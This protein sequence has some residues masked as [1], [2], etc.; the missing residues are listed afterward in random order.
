VI[1][2]LLARPGVPP[3]L[4]LLALAA[5]WEGAARW[6]GIDGLAPA[7]AAIRQL[8]AILLDPESL[9]H[10]IASLRRMAVGFAAALLV[11]VPVG[12]VMGRSRAVAT[13]LN[14]LLATIY[15][16]PKAALMPIIMLWFGIGDLSKELVI[17]LGVS[18]PIVFHAYAGAKAVEEKL[19]WS[20]RAMGMGRA[21]SLLRVVL[22]AAL[23]E[24][25]LGCRVGLVMALIVMVTSEMI[26]RESG[27]GNILFNSLD[28]ALYADV[29]ATILVIGA[30]GFALDAA[31]ERI[32]RA[33]TFWAEPRDA[34]FRGVF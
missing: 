32:R 25:L 23:P 17:F 12:L 18:L 1:A 8:P 20:A 6:A 4:A 10:I 22:P 33:L 9:W 13:A 26:A 31:F 29:Y 14:P 27:V 34:D 11:A 24:I 28:M 16:V 15:P 7:S 5:L 19:L 21:A 30:I 3:L 2:R